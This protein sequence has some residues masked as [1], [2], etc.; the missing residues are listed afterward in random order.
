MS[1]KKILLLVLLVVLLLSGLS[2]WYLF[3]QSSRLS[4]LDSESKQQTEDSQRPDI[5]DA[6]PIL[7]DQEQDFVLAL[8]E[9]IPDPEQALQDQAE[10]AAQEPEEQ[11]ESRWTWIQDYVLTNYFIQ[12]LAEYMV[13]H[14]APPSS[15]DNPEQQG[16]SRLSFKSLNAR[17]GMEL[18]GFRYQEQDPQD[19]RQK[20]LDRVMDSQVLERI[21][22]KYS[23]EFLEQ[24]MQEAKQREWEFRGPEGEVQSR[25]L[26]QEEVADLLQIISS[27]M[28]AVAGVFQT[29]AQDQE[30]AGLVEEYLEQ[31]QK[32]VHANYV[33]N[34]EQN[35]LQLLRRQSKE[36]ESQ[37][38][39]LEEEISEVERKKRDAAQDYRK[40]LQ[41]RERAREELIS[42]L[43][44]GR[45]SKD[46]EDHELLYIAEWVQRRLAQDQG[47]GAVARLA[48][49]LQ[50]LGQSFADQARALQQ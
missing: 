7:Q 25:S 45:S 8:R 28:R 14:Y 30:A 27:Y 10:Q 26:K 5:E 13:A 21:Y 15:I 35:R 43:R 46:L 11:Q 40:A 31:E 20:I 2:G 19:A 38:P 47:Q 1:R 4:R 41:S 44:S 24:V 37:D 39:E 34:Q 18:T 16:K 36:E 29:L 17:Y 6:E 42:D 49:L 22:D 32:A 9:Q 33:L 3:Q 12:D 23:Q 48:E 50:D